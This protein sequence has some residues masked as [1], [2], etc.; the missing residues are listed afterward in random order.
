MALLGSAI[1]AAEAAIAVVII[2]ALNQ[3]S[4]RSSGIVIAVARLNR[5]QGMSKEWPGNGQG[6]ARSWQGDR[7]EMATWWRG[8]ET[9]MAIKDANAMAM[10][11]GNSEES[12]KWWQT[13]WR[14]G[15]T[16]M[17][18]GSDGREM[19]SKGVPRGR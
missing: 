3:T 19:D 16:L 18:T 2:V 4:S 1:L 14:R 7:K 15:A 11:Q 13:E 17:G 8:S 12:I 9:E 5:R 10:R 6:M